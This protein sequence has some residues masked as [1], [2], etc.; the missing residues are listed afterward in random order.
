MCLCR[1]LKGGLSSKV[2][3][4]LHLNV[5][6]FHHV[7]PSNTSPNY[8]PKNKASQYSTPVD[9]AY[10]LDGNWEVGL[11]N[12]SYSSCINTFNND[13][14][15]IK[16]YVTLNE[17]L[18]K[19]NCPPVKVILPIFSSNYTATQA[20]NSYVVYMNKMFQDLLSIQLNDKYATWNLLTDK[21]Y[22]ILSP[23][24]E[25]LFQ[26][27]SDVLTKTDANFKNQAA[28]F[29]RAIPKKDAHVIVV[30]TQA[31]SS[32]KREDIVLKKQ[33]EKITID[34]LI[35][36]FK[37]KV[38]TSFATLST[39]N[40]DQCM[41]FKTADDNK[42]LI[43]NKSFRT[44]LTF[45]RSG[46]FDRGNQR[47]FAAKFEG[48]TDPW[49]LSILNLENIVTYENQK[50]REVVLPPTSFNL[51]SDAVHFVNQRI[52][53]KR[54]LF[55]CDRNKH[56]NLYINTKT[57]TLTFDDTLRD[58]FA[59]DN[60]SYTGTSTHIASG[61]FSLCRRIQYLYIYSNLTEYIRVGNTEAP[62]L[63][64]IPLSYN[65][66]ALHLNEKTFQV[67]MYIKVCRDRISQIDIAIYDGAGQL[68]PFA[69]DS[70]TTLHLH[71]RQS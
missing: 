36:R 12:A 17:F 55:T 35:K 9:N 48:S 3:I 10:V 11:I 40:K 44:A 42:L 8:F 25:F 21:Y 31:S 28:F 18:P 54:I 32:I 5:M 41:L 1:F 64:L 15:T 56:V 37:S 19:T 45:I 63:A 50:V 47:H 33:D 39:F 46:M 16:E 69:S 27:W 13:K 2:D 57:L 23:E 66:S 61:T 52:N 14:M 65:N 43:L 6:D 26:L 60:N 34:G 24:M 59:F 51:E 71:F 67:P 62:L 20:R 70:V 22:F 30:P 29:D 68:I 58:I 49:I 7:L 38:P 53:D 4:M